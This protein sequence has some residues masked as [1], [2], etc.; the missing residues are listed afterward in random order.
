MR[1]RCAR[2]I[3]P[4]LTN[5]LAA[6]ARILREEPRRRLAEREREELMNGWSVWA[7]LDCC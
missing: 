4:N 6:I 2:S 7:E 3:A 5:D 1:R